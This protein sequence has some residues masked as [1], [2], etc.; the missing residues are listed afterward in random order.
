[1]K[2]IAILGSTGSIGKNALS[3]VDTHADEFKVVGLAANRD[4]DALEQ[5]IRRYRPALVAL[6][7]PTAACQ[8]RE[9]IRDLN[10][11]PQ[12]LAGTEGLQVVATMPEVS[13][14]LD[15]MGGSAGLLP[16]LAA[17]NAG[18]DI[19]FVN[20]E[21]MVMAGPLVNAAVQENGV[22]LIPIDG[23]MSAIFQCLEGARDR[24]ADIHRLLITASGGPFREVP[25]EELYSVT[26]QQALQ[27]PNWKMGQKI[28]IDSA[29][30]M[31]KGLEVIEA[32]W[33]F[34]IELSKIDIVVHPES[35]VHSMVE[36]TDGSTLAQLGPTD[37]R[38]MIQYALTYPRRLSTPVPRLDLMES[39]ALHFEP[40]DFEK[41]PCLSLAY[42]AAEVGG[43]LPVVLSSADEVVVEAFLNACIG[44]M[45]IPAILAS[46]MDKHVVIADPT[47][48][49]ILEVDRWA[50]STARS[51]IKNKTQSGV[52]AG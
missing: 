26:P 11:N 27:H 24:Q 7:E 13:Q 42:T 50:K 48:S 44:F 10:G 28:T 52:R 4:V 14:V 36:W 35:I 15:G 18:K 51:I 32:K 17:I 5:Q 22:N 33:L 47:L 43:T 38:I 34:D 2:H 6:N 49:D 46:V 23:E 16:T 19:A 39:R 8:L 41:F 21:V 40:V 25:K 29:T 45:D 37:M 9:R 3:V 30:M 20:K 1:M 31:N 12:V